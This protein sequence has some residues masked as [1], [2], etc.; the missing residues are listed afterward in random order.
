MNS[1]RHANQRRASRRSKSSRGKCKID[2]RRRGAESEERSD[3]HVTGVSI[4][5]SLVGASDEFFDG[6]VHQSEVEVAAAG[7]GDETASVGEGQPR[8]PV[9][10]A[11]L[12]D[13]VQ[14]VR[15]DGFE[16]RWKVHG[17]TAPKGG[18]LLQNGFDRRFIRL[19]SPATVR[20]G[21]RGRC[22]GGYSRVAVDRTAPGIVFA[23]RR[24]A[25][26]VRGTGVL[27]RRTIG[28]H[29]I[30]HAVIVE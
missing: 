10:G 18:N 14:E 29:A 23:G 22:G 6:V 13:A 3:P 15:I 30:T 16:Q 2:E 19:E 12:P 4:R 20:F 27:A 24:R 28:A 9:G 26:V 5:S 1:L 11:S 25:I 7:E 8:R 17:I 21:G